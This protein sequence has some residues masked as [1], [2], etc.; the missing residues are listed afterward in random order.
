MFS[1]NSC[2]NALKWMF[3]QLLSTHAVKIQE[4]TVFINTQEDLMFTSIFES[5]LLLASIQFTMHSLY[6]IH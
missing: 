4:A 2:Y 5:C 1:L 6:H 3:W